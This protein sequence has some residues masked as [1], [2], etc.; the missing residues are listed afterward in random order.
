MLMTADRW[1]DTVQGLEGVAE[2][3]RA[4]KMRL[5]KEIYEQ[6]SADGGTLSDDHHDQLVAAAL[7]RKADREKQEW[8][9]AQKPQE[10]KR[11][12]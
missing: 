2:F 9:S 7:Q 5:F 4:T 12:A 1:L 6:L 11:R 8:A 10:K 3:D